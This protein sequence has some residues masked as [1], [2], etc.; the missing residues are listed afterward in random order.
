MSSTRF[1]RAGWVTLCACAVAWECAARWNASGNFP[2]FLQTITSF[3]EQGPAL[4]QA[5]GITLAR[6]AAGF[7]LALFVMLPLGIMVGRLRLLGQYVEPLIDVLRPLPPL[8]LVPIAMLF[9]GTGSAA[10]ILVVFYSASFPIL[11]SAIS[12]TRATHPVLV[13]TA[14][15]FG[16]SRWEIMRRIDMPAGLPQVAAGVRVAVALAILIS[17]SSEMLLSTDGIGNLI[18]RAQEQFQVAHGLAA[19]L[20]IAAA[21]L[22]VNNG[23]YRLERAWLAWHHQR[24][25]RF[26]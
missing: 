8:A 4:L 15:S 7:A 19:L 22:A 23:L 3:A 9:A 21:A 26:T 6:A 25:A 14:R 11:I 13:Q 2:G 18:M 5:I 20:L 17:V 16:L 1:N 12:A 24:L 10:K